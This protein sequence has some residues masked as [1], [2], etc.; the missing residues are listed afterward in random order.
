MAVVQKPDNASYQAHLGKALMLAL[1]LDEAEVSLRRAIELD[2]KY[3]RSYEYLGLVLLG[4][5]DIQGAIEQFRAGMEAD[6]TLSSNYHNLAAALAN[7]G[8]FD[9][10]ATVCGQAIQHAKDI[11]LTDEEIA[12]FRDRRERYLAQAVQ[13]PASP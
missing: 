2:P 6:P 13:A 7:V 11:K 1:R 5:K 12:G 3:G 10:A 4:K 9:E 8:R